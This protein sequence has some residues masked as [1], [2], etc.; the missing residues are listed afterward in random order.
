MK[1]LIVACIAVATLATG[2]CASVISQFT[3]PAISSDKLDEAGE[4]SKLKTLSGDRRLVRVVAEEPRVDASGAVV[5]DEEGNPYYFYDV[6]AETQADAIF[7]RSPS[8]GLEIAEEGSYTDAIVQAAT[9]TNVRTAVSDVVRQLAWQ[10]CNARMN[11]DLTPE[12]Y[13]QAL[14]HLQDK[15]LEVLLASAAPPKTSTPPP[16]SGNAAPTGTGNTSVAPNASSAASN[17]RPSN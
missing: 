9:Q 5:R 7:T 8:S 17:P 13:R 3:D 16:A 12:E 10:L 11:H 4:L 1:Q 6:C 2:G 14:L 15:A